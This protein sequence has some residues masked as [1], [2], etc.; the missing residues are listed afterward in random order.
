MDSQANPISSTPKQNQATTEINS[1]N[2]ISVENLKPLKLIN[3]GFK[4]RTDKPLFRHFS[5]KDTMAYDDRLQQRTVFTNTKNRPSIA[6]KRPQPRS[7]LRVLPVEKQESE[8]N[9]EESPYCIGCG[10]YLQKEEVKPL[11]SFTPNMVNL[12]DYLEKCKDQRFSEKYPSLCKEIDTLES[13]FDLWKYFTPKTKTF[14]AP[15]RRRY[16][17]S[18]SYSYFVNSQ[19]ESQTNEVLDKEICPWCGFTSPKDQANSYFVKSQ[20]ESQTSKQTLQPPYTNIEQTTQKD[21]APSKDQL[22]LEEQT[23]KTEELVD[24]PSQLTCT[25]ASDCAGL[26]GQGSAFY[27]PGRPKDSKLYKSLDTGDHS[28]TGKH[29]E[30]HQRMKFISDT[31]SEHSTPNSDGT[32]CPWC[33]IIS[34]KEQ[35]ARATIPKLSRPSLR[36]NDLSSY[37]KNCKNLTFYLQHVQQCNSLGIFGPDKAKFEDDSKSMKK[38]HKESDID[39]HSPEENFWSL[40]FPPKAHADE[41]HNSKSNSFSTLGDKCKD[42]TFYKEHTYLCMSLGYFIPTKVHAAGKRR[43]GLDVLNGQEKK[44]LQLVDTGVRLPEENSLWKEFDPDDVSAHYPRIRHADIYDV[45]GQEKKPLKVSDT[46]VRLP[47]KNFWWLFNPPKAHADELHNS[48]QTVP[49]RPRVLPRVLPVERQESETNQEEPPYCIGC[50]MYLQKEQN[51]ES[52]SFE[53]NMVNFIEYSEKCKDQ[54]FSEE[55]PSLC[56]VVKSA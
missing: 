26:L 10:M 49:K 39:V 54:T 30:K 47:E 27:S 36:T 35:N 51:K 13:N 29:S 24:Y 45:N 16:E 37:A 53:P 46:G 20:E 25:N 18:Y 52:Y 50:G 17:D 11:A 23:E 5:P 2:K 31:N 7:V 15:S 40:F 21:T 9:Q 28:Q 6:G 14:A 4:L 38:S 3:T 41:L 48:K 1:E 22:L 12:A 55:Y 33:G 43:P 44:P 34:Q 32:I 8:I 19:E 56:K 42:P